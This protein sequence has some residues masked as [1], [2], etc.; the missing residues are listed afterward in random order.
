MK[1][2]LIL[3]LFLLGCSGGEDL[4]TSNRVLPD[5]G[6]TGIPMHNIEGLEGLRGDEPA[7]KNENLSAIP[8]HPFFPSGND[9]GNAIEILVSGNNKG[10]VLCLE[11]KN[12]APV[13]CS[14]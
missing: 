2:I 7:K 10:N 6:Q 1:V 3:L 5:P 9:A 13:T 8:T 4:K 14:E 12:G 11:F